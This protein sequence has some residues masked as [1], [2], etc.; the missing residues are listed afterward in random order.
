MGVCC[1]PVPVSQTGV[2]IAEE[3]VDPSKAVESRRC[4]CRG[5]ELH[6]D[7]QLVAQLSTD[8]PG[9]TGHAARCRRNGLQP[10]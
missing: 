9:Q 7:S 8:V 6:C 4:Y 1:N 3:I 10:R 2:G 5:R